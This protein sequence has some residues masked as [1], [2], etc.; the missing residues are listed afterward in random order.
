MAVSALSDM[1]GYVGHTQNYHKQ[2]TGSFNRKPLSPSSIM[3]SQGPQ[4]MLLWIFLFSTHFFHLC[5]LA[6]PHPQVYFPHRGQDEQMPFPFNSVG[7][8]S[9]FSPVS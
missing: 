4:E 2:N 9:L 7:K 1:A 6:E 8:E 3:K 5:E